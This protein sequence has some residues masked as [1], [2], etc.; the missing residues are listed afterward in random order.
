MSLWRRVCRSLCHQRAC[1]LSRRQR[2][3]TA[4]LHCRPEYTLAQCLPA[5]LASTRQ[6]WRGKTMQP[7]TPVT[8]TSVSAS[9]SAPRSRGRSVRTGYPCTARM[10][11]THARVLTKYIIDIADHWP[12]LQ[13]TFLSESVAIAS[14]ATCHAQTPGVPPRRVRWRPQ[15]VRVYAT[16]ACTYRRYIYMRARA[17]APLPP[18]DFFP[19]M[20]VM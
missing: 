15:R 5:L 10:I 6:A 1:R 4:W 18:R 9:G 14:Q 11:V 7:C 8:G 19:S 2:L 13:P 20:L 12:E 3:S 16:R 17:R